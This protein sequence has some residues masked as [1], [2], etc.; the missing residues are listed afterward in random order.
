M[1]VNGTPSTDEGRDFVSQTKVETDNEPLQL[2]GH[3]FELVI[4]RQQK[5]TTAKSTD[6]GGDYPIQADFAEN[7]NAVIAARDAAH[8]EAA[9]VKHRQGT[10]STDENKQY[11]PGGTGGDPLIYA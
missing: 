11:D 1:V 7:T 8:E 5:G 6:W 10:V 9:N 2:A 4:F 3:H